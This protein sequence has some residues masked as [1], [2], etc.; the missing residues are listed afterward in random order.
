MPGFRVCTILVMI[1]MFVAVFGRT[2][3][4]SARGDGELAAATQLAKDGR[5]EGYYRLGRVHELGQEVDKDLFEAARQYQLA[6]ERGHVEAQ[7]ALGLLLT[8]AVPDSPH[9]AR[10]SFDWFEKAA[11]QG[12]AKAAHFLAMRYETGAGTEQNSERA[13]EWYRRASIGGNSESMSALARMYAT[14]AGIRMNLANA[15]AWNRV[16]GARGFEGAQQY[17]AELEARMSEEDIARAGRLVGGLM[18]KY[19]GPPDD[20]RP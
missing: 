7:F 16:A 10:E 11:Q 5:A 6:A 12:H 3:L 2:Q 18:K 14:G 19:G 13:F 9:S 4:S 20:R 17:A 1:P 15:H 8:G